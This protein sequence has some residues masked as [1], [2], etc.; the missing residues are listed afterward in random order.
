MRQWETGCVVGQIGLTTRRLA[1][2][3]AKSSGKAYIHDQICSICLI[4]TLLY[5]SNTLFVSYSAA[6]FAVSFSVASAA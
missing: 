1:S 4:I 2:I 5:S 6:A 3:I